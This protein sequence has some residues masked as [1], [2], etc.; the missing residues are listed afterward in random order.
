[1]LP[2]HIYL[3]WNICRH[4]AGMVLTWTVQ[5]KAGEGAGGDPAIASDLE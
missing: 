3:P 4:R 2:V 1:M 5:M